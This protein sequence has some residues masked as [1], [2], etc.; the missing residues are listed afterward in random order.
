VAAGAS[1]A[2]AVRA[3]RQALRRDP[4]LRA[5]FYSCLLQVVGLGQ[6]PALPARR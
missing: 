4:A 6:E 5:P 1:T 2:E 3:A